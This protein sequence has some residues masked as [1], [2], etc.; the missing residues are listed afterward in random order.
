MKRPKKK[1]PGKQL[2]P[3]T[4]TEAG[5]HEELHQKMQALQRTRR[6][7]FAMAA[8]QGI[9]TSEFMLRI[10]SAEQKLGGTQ[11]TTAIAITAYTIADEMLKQRSKKAS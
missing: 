10:I 6:D 8:P 3:A 11:M 7:E 4:P 5:W 2:R 9:A 1:P